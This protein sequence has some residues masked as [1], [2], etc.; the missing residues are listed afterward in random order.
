MD[1]IIFTILICL[2]F[3]LQSHAGGLSD[4]ADDDHLELTR[5]QS[6][7]MPSDQEEL[8]ASSTED[9]LAA[10]KAM[11]MSVHES[12]SDKSLVWGC[13]FLKMIK[14]GE[15]LLSSLNELHCNQNSA[16]NEDNVEGVEDF[17][18]NDIWL[19]I[20]DLCKHREKV[21]TIY[22]YVLSSTKHLQVD[23]QICIPT[24]VEPCKQLILNDVTG[25]GTLSL[26]IEAGLSKL[27]SRIDAF[28]GQNL[29]D[30]CFLSWKNGGSNT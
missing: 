21:K 22:N 3:T 26:A 8:S 19:R 17:G 9:S 10:S 14:E 27:L 24:C 25:M 12:I 28:I 30:D 4:N 1:K 20:Q 23:S 15:G 13:V 6:G 11:Y 16:E 5:I 7:K 2:F 18:E 29:C